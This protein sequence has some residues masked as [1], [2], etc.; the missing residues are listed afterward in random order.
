MRT[1]VPQ[2]SYFLPTSWAMIWGGARRMG[3]GK[4]TRERLLQKM[5]RTPKR[6]SGVLSLGFLYRTDRATTPEGR[7]K[8]SRL[9]GVQNPFWEGCP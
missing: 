3:G 6:A 8:H 2:K 4:R 5:F 9:R 1:F 7:G